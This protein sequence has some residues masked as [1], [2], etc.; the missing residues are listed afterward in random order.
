MKARSISVVG[1]TLLMLGCQKAPAVTGSSATV[2][3]LTIRDGVAWGLASS[4]SSTVGFRIATT[5][6]DTLIG[7]ESPDGSATLHDTAGG[8]MK[9]L[10][11]LSVAAGTT[12]VLGAGGPHIMLTGAT[13]G[14]SPGDSVRIV[15]TWS[16]NGRLAFS[17]PLRNFSDASGLLGR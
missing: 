1:G 4:Q 11:R 2:G 9:P 17:V 13:H 14:F 8:G 5:T 10:E 12:V 15:L 6:A 7:V 16:R 3:D